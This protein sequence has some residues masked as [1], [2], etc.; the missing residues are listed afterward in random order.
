MKLTSEKKAGTERQKQ[1]HVQAQVKPVRPVQYHIGV[2]LS[3]TRRSRLAL[4]MQNQRHLGPLVLSASA[5]HHGFIPSQN[6][7]HD[8]D[9]DG[10]PAPRT[11]TPSYSP[12]FH[13]DTMNHPCSL[14][15]STPLSPNPCRLPSSSTPT[16]SPYITHPPPSSH[17]YPNHIRIA[18]LR[19]LTLSSSPSALPQLSLI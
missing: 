12:H 10:V 4:I 7:G 8:Q 15:L 17:S 13:H 1:M 2:N 5:S 6:A 11:L 9:E 14:S 16:P 18:F 19:T 3:T